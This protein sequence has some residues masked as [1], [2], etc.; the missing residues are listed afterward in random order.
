LYNIFDFIRDNFQESRVKLKQMINDNPSVLEKKTYYGG[1]SPLH[2]AIERCSES[3]VKFMLKKGA[4]PMR[5]NKQ[6]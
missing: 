6:E 3:I 4:D 5:R 2:F 1:K